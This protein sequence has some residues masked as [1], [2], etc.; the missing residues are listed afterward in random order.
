M[1]D[2]TYTTQRPADPASTHTTTVI[3]RRSS[4][5]GILIAVVLLIAVIG[6]IWLFSQRSAS[7]NARDNAVAEAASNVGEAASKVGNAAE[8]AVD[9]SSK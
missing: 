8:D 6:G 4:G 3:E 9:T 7:E 2:E 1:A 5:G